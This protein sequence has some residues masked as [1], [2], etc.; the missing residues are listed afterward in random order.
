MRSVTGTGETMVAFSVVRYR[1]GQTSRSREVKWYSYSL[2][3]PVHPGLQTLDY[4]R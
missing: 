2:Y 3:S 1:F 4:L